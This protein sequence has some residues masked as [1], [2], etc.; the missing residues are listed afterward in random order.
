[1]KQRL[2]TG[3]A[4][5]GDD[6]G[7][8]AGFQGQAWTHDHPVFEVLSVMRG[9]VRQRARTESVLHDERASRW[10]NSLL[11]EANDV[12]V[13]QEKSKLEL[14]ACKL[15]WQAHSDLLNNLDELLAFGSRLRLSPDGL[16][17]DPEGPLVP[18]NQLDLRSRQAAADRKVAEIEFRRAV[19]HLKFVL[20]LAIKGEC[21]TCH[22]D[23]YFECD[24]AG[25]SPPG[26]LKCAHWFCGACIR[27]QLGNGRRLRCAL[28]RA[29]TASDELQYV[30]ASAVGP[31]RHGG[32]GW[33]IHC[34]EASAVQ[35]ASTGVAKHVKGS[36]GTKISRLV[37]D[38]LEFERD[39]DVNFL[40]V[41]DKTEPTGEHF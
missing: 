40:L 32:D 10:W 11:E 5:K 19:S 33:G 30:S 38:V 7:G 21:A 16:P 3:Y 39:W 20:T 35:P 14:K 4:R 12:H 8:N 15:V 29:V 18:R 23:P 25:W 41:V 9:W 2:S 36:W 27:R 28:C 17:V 31:G 26:L 34:G 37:E 13:W 24:S 22:D 6:A 1:M